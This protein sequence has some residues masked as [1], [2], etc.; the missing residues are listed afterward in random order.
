[1]Q[2]GITP[3]R[4]GQKKLFTYASLIQRFKYA[5]PLSTIKLFIKNFK[6]DIK[7]CLE[8]FKVVDKCRTNLTLKICQKYL[9]FMQ[10]EIV[11]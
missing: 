6:L 4:T 8:L 3:K 10:R 5:R 9:L 1:M 2:D 7:L 11:M